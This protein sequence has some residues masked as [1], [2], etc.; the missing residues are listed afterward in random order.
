[1]VGLS[2]FDGPP[3]AID[4]R[5]IT[6]R[7]KEHPVELAVLFGSYVS[8][9]LHSLSDVD[10]GVI[11]KEGVSV[12]KRRQLLD[13]MV[14]EIGKITNHDRIDVVDLDVVPARIGYT[15]LSR[16]RLLIGDSDAAT[17]LEAQLLLRSLDFEPVLETWTESLR[18]RLH[19]GS[20]GRA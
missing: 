6:E 3:D 5:E 12:E 2:S 15:A 8:D 16:G 14:A 1:M 11:F 19:D 10:I 17:Q 7:L 13:T 4:E 20:Y 18:S 9:R